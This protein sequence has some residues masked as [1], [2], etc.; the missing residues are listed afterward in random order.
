MRAS[1]L[2]YP[3]CGTKLVWDPVGSEVAI[4]LSGFSWICPYTTVSFNFRNKPAQ[5]K[6]GSGD[7]R[8]S[9]KCTFMEEHRNT[10]CGTPRKPGSWLMVLLTSIILIRAQCDP[11]FRAWKCHP[12]TRVLYP[13][14]VTSQLYNLEQVTH[15]LASDFSTVQCRAGPG[16]SKLP[17]T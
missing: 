2:G 5:I 17:L 14:P 6:P 13:G 3:H 16:V 9:P 15:L 7:K 8:M 11:G 10:V 12:E 4:C 1:I